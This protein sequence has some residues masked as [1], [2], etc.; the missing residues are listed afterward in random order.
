M[1]RKKASRK[2]ETTLVPHR[3][4]DLSSLLESARTGG[5]TQ[6]AEAYRNA[7]GS[8]AAL[9]DLPRATGVQRLPLMHS[10]ALTSSHPHTHLAACVELLVAA[11]A[12]MNSTCSGGANE[13]HTT[14]IIAAERGCC[15]KPLQVFLRNGAD[16]SL[17]CAKDRV[18]ALHKAA[19][20]GL[21]AHCQLLL[22]SGSHVDAMEARGDTA[23]THAVAKGHVDVVQLLHRHGADICKAGTHSMTPIH[24]AA[25]LAGVGVMQYLLAN[26]AV[27]GAVDDE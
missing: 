19:G 11:G 1:A 8:P 24:L 17:C 6:A 2:Q 27:V 4:P 26:G 15:I 23:L 25:S 16:P 21:A 18:T 9:V 7:G 12:D 5:S 3:T 22:D 20:S 13:M 14:V 10:I